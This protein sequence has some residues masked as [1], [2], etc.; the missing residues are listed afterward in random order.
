[1]IKKILIIFILI[2]FILPSFANA[3]SFIF[4]TTPPSISDMQF[5]TNAGIAFTQGQQFA[6]GANRILLNGGDIVSFYIRNTCNFEIPFHPNNDIFSLDENSNLLHHITFPNA[7]TPVPANFEGWIDVPLNFTGSILTSSISVGYNFPPNASSCIQQAFLISPSYPLTP[8]VLLNSP[9]NVNMGSISIN[10]AT[11]T[12]SNVSP[13]NLEFVVSATPANYSIIVAWANT[14]RSPVYLGYFDYDRTTLI[15]N[16]NITGAGVFLFNKDITLNLGNNFIRAFLVD[17]SNRAYVAYSDEIY[18]SF[19]DVVVPPPVPPTLNE[20]TFIEG[21]GPTWLEFVS[22]TI[23]QT[24]TAPIRAILNFVSNGF[25]SVFP[26]SWILRVDE[27]ISQNINNP[28]PNVEVF[29]LSIPM[30]QLS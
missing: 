17:N 18:I 27:V 8:A 10:R 9:Q 5:F 13:V 3:S 26:L 30:Q 1:M 12:S 2:S 6:L 29:N 21:L 16:V 20:E 25:R 15:E 19:S 28:T 4:S 23:F 22:S 14:S 24:A 7:N 11:S